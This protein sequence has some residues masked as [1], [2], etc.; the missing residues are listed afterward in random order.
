MSVRNI[1]EKDKNMIFVRFSVAFV[2]AVMLCSK[3][4][5]RAEDGKLELPTSEA[6]GEIFDAMQQEIERLDGATL[7]VRLARSEPW[8][9]TMSRLRAEAVAANSL[10]AWARA[11]NRVDNT[12]PNLHSYIEYGSAFRAALPR[13]VRFSVDFFA[14]VHSTRKS[15]F[16]ISWIDSDLNS[17]SELRPQVGDRLIAINGRSMNEWRRE[18]VIFCK[19][20]LPSQCDRE[21]R[22]NFRAE[23]LGWSRSEPLS[24]TLERSG[25]R[26]NIA[27]PL[28]E[29]TMLSE[30]YAD[31]HECALTPSRYTGFTLS[32]AGNRA[33]VYESANRSDTAILR[34]TRFNYRKSGTK[35]SIKSASEEVAALRPWWNEHANWK[36]LII[37]VIGNGGGQAPIEFYRMLLPEAFQEQ[38]VRLRKLFELDDPNLRNG[39][40]WNSQEHEIWFQNLREHGSYDAT[41][42]G[43]FLPPVPQ[44]CAEENRDCTQ[45][46]FT[47]YGHPFLGRVSILVDQFCISSCDGF[48]WQLADK[49]RGR[50]RFVGQPPAGDT[51]WSRLIIDVV[52]DDKRSGFFKTAVRPLYSEP[53]VERV[54]SQIV[55][56][57]LSTD[58]QGNRLDGIPFSVDRFV[59]RTLENS[60]NWHNEALEAALED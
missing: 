14:E 12:Y 60:N 1:P 38:Y 3:N 9:N 47:P 32:Y 2:F 51:A 21:L 49:L 30:K 24:Y 44:F 59:P 19:F 11:L 33:C 37:D 39:I 50:V 36:H 29:P 28:L 8:K 40:L 48:V 41:K 52:P 31:M 16:K 27:V 26:W 22:N 56:I 13:R 43:S 35:S 15:E 57:S 7:Q 25:V 20:A 34:I 4:F 46:T 55:N 53:P 58:A 23:L 42:I 54:Y 5:A 6:R 10:A 18:N 45:G 17:G